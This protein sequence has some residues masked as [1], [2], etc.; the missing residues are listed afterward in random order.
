MV[1]LFPNYLKY[2]FGITVLELRVTSQLIYADNDTAVL[3]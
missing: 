1:V 3:N 2:I